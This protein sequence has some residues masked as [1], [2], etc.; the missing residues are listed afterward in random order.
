MR[1]YDTLK[2]VNRPEFSAPPPSSVKMEINCWL[3]RSRSW[4]DRPPCSNRWQGHQWRSNRALISCPQRKKA[5]RPWK[6]K[7]LSRGKAPGPDTIHVE[8]WRNHNAKTGRDIPVYVEWREGPSTAQRC[9]HSPHLQK[10]GKPPSCDSHWVFL[11][12]S[13]LARP[14]SASRLTASS[15][16]LSRVSYQK[17]SVVSAHNVELLTWY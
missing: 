10:E 14:W 6:K 13:L 17:T 16:I 8:L 9:Q 3:R 11:S 12:Y 7:K 1:F 5:E 15:N 4:R 2:T